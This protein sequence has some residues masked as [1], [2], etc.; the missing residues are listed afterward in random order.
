MATVTVTL[1]NKRCTDVLSAKYQLQWSELPD[2]T[3][4]PFSYADARKELHVAAGYSPDLCRAVLVDA[5]L[6]GKAEAACP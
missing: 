2:Q 4:G 6:N 1:T 5:F 3:F